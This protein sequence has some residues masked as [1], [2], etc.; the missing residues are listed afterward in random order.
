MGKKKHNKPGRY[1]IIHRNRAGNRNFL[2]E[3]L[4]IKFNRQICKTTIKSTFKEIK[5][6]YLKEVMIT[7]SHQIKNINKETEIIYH[8]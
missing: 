6:T 4:D 8:N 1:M 2:G 5:R 3:G 7:V